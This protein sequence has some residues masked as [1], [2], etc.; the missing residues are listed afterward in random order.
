MAGVGLWRLSELYVILKVY[1]VR[2]LVT[3]RESK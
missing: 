2:L 3:L 1:E